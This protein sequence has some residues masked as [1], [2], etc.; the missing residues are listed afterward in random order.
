MSG[1]SKMATA[2][3]S[4]R[5]NPVDDGSVTHG[6]GT[7]KLWEKGFENPFFSIVVSFFYGSHS[8]IS[9]SDYFLTAPI[10]CNYGFNSIN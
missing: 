2:T 4:T 6:L 9:D 10:I 5:R 1:L 7:V 8:N 3:Y